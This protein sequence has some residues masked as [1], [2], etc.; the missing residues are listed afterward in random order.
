MIG[1]HD[2]FTYLNAED[3]AINIFKPFWKCQKYDINTLYTKYGVRF[4][5]IRICQNTTASLI[6]I[7][8]RLFKKKKF[9]WA[10]AHG[11]AEFSKTFNNVED[12]FKYMKSNFPEATYRIILE[13][14]SKNEKN[15]F[16]QQMSKWTGGKK[17]NGAKLKSAGYKCAWIGLK[18]PWEEYYIDNDLYPKN[19]KDYCCTLFNWNT[20][21]SL[22]ENIK[23]FRADYT[24]ES[25]AKRNNPKLTV[26]EKNDPN[27]L[28][29]MD[30]VGVYGVTKGPSYN[31]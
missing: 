20:N 8:G 18:S 7:I 15:T 6:G 16:I 28:Y 23:N 29:F 17:G 10:T 3:L 2:T 13:R 22:S 25:W 31:G 30:Y 9:T 26:A 1:A 11:L 4:F 14:C 21:R 12:I 19:V 24:I 27:T 5:D